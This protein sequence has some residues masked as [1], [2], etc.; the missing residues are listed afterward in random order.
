LEHN[1]DVSLQELFDRPVVVRAAE[2]NS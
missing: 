1:A 2:G